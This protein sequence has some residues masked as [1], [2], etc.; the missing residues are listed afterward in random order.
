MI[1]WVQK[2]K[3]GD[4]TSKVPG[5]CDSPMQHMK[6]NTIKLALKSTLTALALTILAFAFSG[7][8]S[9]SSGSGGGTHNM[10][11]GSQRGSIPMADRN[12]PG[13]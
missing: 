6:T 10:G 3:S 8:E 5:A 13:R 1:I 2:N 12:M 4:D 11:S 7:C 9:T